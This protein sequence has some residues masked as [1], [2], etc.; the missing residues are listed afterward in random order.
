MRNR[1]KASSAFLTVS[2]MLEV[3]ACGIGQRACGDKLEEI[4]VVLIRSPGRFRQAALRLGIGNILK[5][6]E[7]LDLNPRGVSNSSSSASV[8]RPAL[9][10]RTELLG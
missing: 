4:L 9:F 3:V 5:A 2:L 6:R 8:A 10:L 7:V 1:M